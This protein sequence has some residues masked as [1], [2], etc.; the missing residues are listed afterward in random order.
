MASEV[1]PAPPGALIHTTRWSRRT[2]SSNS[3][4][5]SRANKFVARGAVSFGGSVRFACVTAL[6][7]LGWR[8]AVCFVGL[9]VAAAFFLGTVTV[10]SFIPHSIMVH[11][12]PGRPVI[13]AQ[14]GHSKKEKRPRFRGLAL[15][16][17]TK[18][19]KQLHH[20]VHAAHAGRCFILREF[21]DHGL[22]GDH[23]T[24]GPTPRSGAPNA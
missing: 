9:V 1:L 5:R 21:R 19:T 14:T 18:I 12:P 2:R 16:T 4:K 11:D 7:V 22:G 20:P 3:N 10:H 24:G 15:I 8:V 23:D 17:L 6:A 13:Y